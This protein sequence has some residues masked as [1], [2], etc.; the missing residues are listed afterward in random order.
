M[1]F[2]LGFWE[3]SRFRYCDPILF[4]CSRLGLNPNQVISIGDDEKDT[5]ASNAAGAI[6]IFTTW[7]STSNVSNN[8][9]YQCNSVNELV[10]VL[11]IL[12]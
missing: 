4:G 9:D 7:G 11:S 2:V 5:V 1:A 12:K 10:N 6:S 3:A 8:H